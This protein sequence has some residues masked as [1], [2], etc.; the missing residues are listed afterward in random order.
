MNKEK[1]IVKTTKKPPK[2]PVRKRT[3]KPI[4]K[5]TNNLPVDLNDIWETLSRVVMDNDLSKL[6]P[7]E[8][9][10]YYHAYCNSLGLNSITK[11]FDFIL[12]DDGKGGKKLVLYA[13]KNASEQLRK[14]YKI[15]IYNIELSE[16][17]DEYVCMAYARMPDGREDQ[18][19]GV[20]SKYYYSKKSNGFQKMTGLMAVNSRMK[21]VTKAKR[22]VTLSLA[23]LDMVDESEL[24]TI[25]GLQFAKVDMETGKIKDITKTSN[26]VDEKEKTNELKKIREFLKSNPDVNKIVISLLKYTKDWNQNRIINEINLCKWDKENVL[27][28]LGNYLEDENIKENN[29]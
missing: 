5:K 23:G 19:I 1:D 24:D 17:D 13:L 28:T 20:V 8:R 10:L 29:K 6:K 21:V 15:S 22:R 2:K 12:M 25:K 9:V 3:K 4:V 14:K 18:D 27:N 26:V 16:T 11:P 7:E